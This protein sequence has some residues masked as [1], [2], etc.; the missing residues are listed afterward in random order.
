MYLT[1]NQ[2]FDSTYSFYLFHFILSYLSCVLCTTFEMFYIL[3]VP[4]L[5]IHGT[6][7][8]IKITITITLSFARNWRYSSTHSYPWQWVVEID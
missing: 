7:N 8:K 1:W 4:L 6:L 2:L 3:P 5:W